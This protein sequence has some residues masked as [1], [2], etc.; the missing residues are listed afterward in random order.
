MSDLQFAIGSL[1]YVPFVPLV[2]SS[3][4][5]GCSPGDC[6][7]ILKARHIPAHVHQPPLA[8][9]WQHPVRE[10]RKL[11]LEVF[12]A[13]RVIE[14]AHGMLDK[15]IEVPAVFSDEGDADLVLMDR[16]IDYSRDAVAQGRD[17][18]VTHRAVAE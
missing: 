6:S 9:R 3:F 5:T 2:V 17:G 11:G 10:A 13:H 8:V 1:F 4:L 15:F 18:P 12:V 14:A 16:R 7:S